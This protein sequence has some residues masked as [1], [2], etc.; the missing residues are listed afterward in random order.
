VINKIK[1]IGC[2]VFLA[3]LC[4]CNWQI[5]ETNPIQT[6]TVSSLPILVNGTTGERLDSTIRG[7]YSDFSGMILIAQN[8]KI[9]LIKGHGLADQEKSVPNTP[10][11]QFAI[12]SITKSF[13]AMSIMILKERRLLTLQDSICQYLPD[14]PAPWEPITLQKLLTHTSGIYDLTLNPDFQTIGT[15]QEHEPE[16][17]MALYEEHALDFPPGSQFHYSSSGYQLL[18]MVIEKVSGQK[19]DDFVQENILD[20][21][22]MADTS[23]N[24]ASRP[25]NIRATGY[26]RDPWTQEKIKVPCYDS[27]MFFAAG[28]LYSTVE[29]LYKWDQALYTNQLVSKESL[30]QIFTSTV[31]VV[32]SPG[33]TVPPGL[34]YY[35]YGWMI[36]QQS[37]HRLIKHGGRI[38]GFTAYLARYPDDQLTI[39]ILSNWDRLN[40][41]ELNDE[42]AAMIL[43]KK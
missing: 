43:E 32:A 35:G 38:P 22:G 39:I 36:T 28:G 8:G 11:T 27:S 9:L 19:Y 12:G 37:G 40:P 14:C 31:T 30:S 1:R 7:H 24:S 10:Q 25:L 13:T 34:W 26:S 29:D 42:L 21:L 33:F 18:G 20:P 6:G 17:L 4:A 15:C 2:F 41:I 23:N 16:E 5:T 3:M